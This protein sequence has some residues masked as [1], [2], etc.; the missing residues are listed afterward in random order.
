MEEVGRRVIAVGA[1]AVVVAAQ[2]LL[3]SRLDRPGLPGDLVVHH[4]NFVFYSPLG[5]SLML[6]AL[7]TLAISLLSRK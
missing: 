5:F 4:G 1:L 3:L 6:S 7:L 2:A